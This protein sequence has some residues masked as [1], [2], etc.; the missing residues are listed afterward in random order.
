MKFLIC[1]FF[2]TIALYRENY[3]INCCLNIIE[4]INII[5]VLSKIAV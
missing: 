3:F 4:N 5:N 2:V 1:F